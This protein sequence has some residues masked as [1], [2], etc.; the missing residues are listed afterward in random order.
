MA[1]N[2]V[3]TRIEETAVIRPGEGQSRASRQHSG[4][5][6][7]IAAVLITL[8]LGGIAVHVLRA[9]HAVAPTISQVIPSTRMQF[10]ENNTTNLPNAVTA[11]MGQRATSDEQ[12][13]LDVNTTWLP[14]GMGAAPTV[15]TSSQR[16]FLEV[17]TT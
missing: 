10:V 7:V 13:W 6:G 17:N 1:E 2:M 15:L 9:S 3:E 8:L 11:V 12:R 4:G 14:A 16:W 5:H